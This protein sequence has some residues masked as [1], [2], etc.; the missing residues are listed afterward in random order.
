M[1]FSP[2]KILVFLSLSSRADLPPDHPIRNQS[3]IAVQAAEQKLPTPT[4]PSTSNAAPFD[5]SE[6]NQRTDPNSLDHPWSPRYFFL[7]PQTIMPSP[8]SGVKIDG[9]I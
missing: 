6:L 7:F 1:R 4:P 9:S 3:G 8:E 2:K 5:A